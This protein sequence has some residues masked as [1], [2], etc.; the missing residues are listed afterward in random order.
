MAGQR[1]R[2]SWHAGSMMRPFE[3][4]MLVRLPDAQREACSSGLWGHTSQHNTPCA[5]QTE[6]YPPSEH[7]RACPPTPAKML[8][9]SCDG[10]A[11]ITPCGSKDY[12]PAPITSKGSFALNVL[13]CMSFPGRW[14][15]HGFEC[16]LALRWACTLTVSIDIHTDTKQSACDQRASRCCDQCTTE[17]S[18]DLR[19]R[20][21]QRIPVKGERS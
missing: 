6:R 11:P 3:P 20:G 16:M 14:G 18:R 5:A 17:V 8:G 9:C 10:C 19:S 13:R 1:L 7:C 15:L 2:L 4:Q 21:C 12:K